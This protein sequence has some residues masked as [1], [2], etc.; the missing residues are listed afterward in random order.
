M[1]KLA[2]GAGIARGAQSF[3]NSFMQARQYENQQKMMKHQV[4]LQAL[5]RQLED[6]T[7]PYS[8][9]A[10]L[11]DSIPGLIGVNSPVPLSQQF[12][13]HDLLDDDVEVEEGKP[14]IAGTKGQEASTITDPNAT[15]SGLADTIGQQAT[16]DTADI[17]ATGPTIVKMGDLSPARYKQLL[18][19]RQDESDTNRETEKAKRI[20]EINFDLQQKSYKAQGYTKELARGVDTNTGEYRVLLSNSE[21]DVKVAKMPKGF[22]PL[23]VLV[24]QTRGQNSALPASVRALTTYYESQPNPLT[25]QNY[26]SEEARVEAL[27][28]YKER[29]DIFAGLG[30]AQ[31]KET[32]TRTKQITSGTQPPSPAEVAAGV[33]ADRDDTRADTKNI[34]EFQKDV[35]SNASLIESYTSQIG[36]L[37]QQSLNLGLQLG[38]LKEQ[39]DGEEPTAEDNPELYKQW[40]ATQNDL[41]RVT[42]Q[43]QD[44]ET[45]LERARASHK[46]ALNAVQTYSQGVSS[47]ANVQVSQSQIDTFRKNNANNPRVRNM[48]DEEIKA[49]LIR[50]R[51]KWQ[52]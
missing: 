1:P 18:K 50:N 37:N 21:G 11:I 13:L 23:E 26:T 44:T 9:R 47:T 16:Q 36:R 35:D 38:K 42:K 15:A 45:L 30:E 52:R 22:I 39:N 10:K 7:L 33:R 12:G 27:R 31:K 25:G 24:A 5:Y 32:L 8:Q 3:V 19:N 4:I 2:I 20:A 51:N 49:I 34:I 48:P 28:V 43:V 40:Q 46:A 41:E 17:P 29:G 6:D 14:A